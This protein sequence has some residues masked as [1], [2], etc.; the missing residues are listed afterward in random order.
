MNAPVVFG[1][2]HFFMWTPRKYWRDFLDAQQPLGGARLSVTAVASTSA[3]A[4]VC[5]LEQSN[6]RRNR[7]VCFSF[8]SPRMS[9]NL[10]AHGVVKLLKRLDSK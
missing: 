3:L 7:T 1:E 5:Q 10:H 8:Y 4:C 6:R 2:F 9:V